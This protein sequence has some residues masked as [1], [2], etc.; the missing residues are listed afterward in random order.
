MTTETTPT[1]PT[2]ETSVGSDADT[3]LKARH[4]AMWALGDYHAVATEVI[5]DLGPVL[6]EA[7]HLGPGDH[8]LD[9]AAGS[10]NVAIPAAA[11]G[12]HVIASDL[13]PELLDQGRTDAGAAGVSLEWQVGDAENLPYDDNSFDAV[14]SCVGVM[15]APHHQDAADEL[16]R[17][18]RPGGR[19]GLISWTPTG[20]IGQLFATMK[21]YV[22]PPP[23]GAQPPPL[24]GDIE[25]VRALLGDRVTNVRA[26]QQLLSAGDLSDPVAF[27]EYFKSNYGPT[28]AAYRGLAEDPERT[29][30]LDQALLDLVERFRTPDGSV[31]WE[32]LLVVA[33]KV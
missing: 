29:A 1:T 33:T 21:P 7:T 14:T 5:P 6:V 20:F 19:I 13:T 16:V 18:C 11:T 15:F 30:E 28:I 3:A 23:P 25:H 22:A 2:T 17:V 26:S 10:G 24:W 8:V 12:A 31:E 32:Y 4:R 9:V 27:R